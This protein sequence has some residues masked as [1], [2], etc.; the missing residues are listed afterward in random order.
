M[1]I[2]VGQVAV[3]GVVRANTDSS[4]IAV[5]DFDID[6]ADGGVE[7]S[8]AGVGRLGVF[9][10]AGVA[11]RKAFSRP[12]TRKENHVRRAVLKG[13][14]VGAQDKHRPSLAISNETDTRPDVDGPSEAITAGGQKQNALIGGF[15]YFVD[16]LLQGIRVVGNAVALDRKLVRREVHSARIVQAAGE[17]GSGQKRASETKKSRER[18]QFFHHDQ[19]LE[20]LDLSRPGAQPI[21]ITEKRSM[22]YSL[23]GKIITGLIVVRVVLFA[24]IRVGARTAAVA[25]LGQF[26]MSMIPARC[27]SKGNNSERRM[28]KRGLQD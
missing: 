24:V 3:L 17:V 25:G 13:W 22:D 9:A 14:R 21:K 6:V 19:F 1:K 18:K 20:C 5:L 4:R 23:T 28:G 16:G 7:G 15:L 10:L 12:A 27:R 11:S 26:P 8:R 2:H